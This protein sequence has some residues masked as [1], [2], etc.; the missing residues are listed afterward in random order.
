MPPI[1][2]Q[3]DE[4]SIAEAVRR[5]RAG[6]VVAFPTETVYGLGADTFNPSALKKIYELKGRP[7]DN[8]L[9]A[10]VADVEVAKRIV[11]EWDERCDRLAQRFWPGPL[12]I[13][14]PKAREVPGEATAGLDTIAVRCPDHPVAIQLL[15]EFGSAISAPSANKSGGVSPT[16]A[17]HVAADFAA[18][19]L[20]IIDGGTCRV[21]IESTVVELSDQ[22]GGARVLRPGSVSVEQLREVLGDVDVANANAQSHSP[23]TSPVH[24]AP[25]TPAVIVDTNELQSALRATTE[26]AVVLSFDTNKIATPHHS[27]VMPR[28]PITYAAQLYRSL[29]DADSMNVSRIVIE[30]PP[31]DAA[32]TAINDRLR[33]ATVG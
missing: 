10:H 33:R 6:S 15:R 18:T 7:F 8:P 24:Y 26:P 2:A 16:E 28:D 1:V 23:G 3:P 32:W 11:A 21:G 30:R 4:K 13:V 20:F 27:I 12:T 9:I 19:D 29:R 14:L 5:L 22:S 31:S 25:R 17:K